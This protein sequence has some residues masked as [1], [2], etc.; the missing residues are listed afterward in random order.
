MGAP[1]HLFASQ[2]LGCL[3]NGLVFAN[4]EPATGFVFNAYLGK[5]GV[6][7]IYFDSALE[8]FSS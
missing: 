7:A 6:I 8:G 4:I 5:L 2:F 1:L 3:R